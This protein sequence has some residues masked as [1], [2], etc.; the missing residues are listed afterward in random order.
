[1]A[2]PPLHRRRFL[3]TSAA[4]SSSLILSGPARAMSLMTSANDRINLG[5]IGIGMMGRSH[6]NAF[7]G[8]DDVQVVAVCDIEGTRRDNAHKQVE[9]RYAERTKS[10][11]Y[12]GCTAYVDF[13]ELLQRED[14]DAVV[15]ATPDHMHVIPC[16]MAATAGKDIYCEKPL[17]HSIHEGRM[18][19]DCVRKYETVFQ[20]GS[21]Q[22]SEFGG[23]FR[24]A[25]ELVRNG[26]LGE[27]KTVRVGVG[28]PPISCDL[29]AEDIPD[30]VNWD[31]WLGPAA[32]RPYSEILC[33]KGMHKHFPAFR[34]YQEFAGGGLADM[35]A[36][37]FDIAQWALGMDES[38]PV[39]IT[40]PAG[41]STSGLKFTYANGVEMFHG[42]PSGC[43]F[44][45]TEGTL[46][47]DRGQI[48]SDPGTILET[49]LGDADQRVYFSDNHKRN[50]IECI[51]TRK[52]PICDVEVGHRS[53]SICHLANISYRLGETLAWNPTTERFDSTEA[54]TLLFR[55]PRDGWTYDMG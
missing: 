29:P 35:G 23:K 54:N 40:P 36:H 52:R 1:M 44:E 53:A 41:G 16:M 9:S 39:K 46:Y 37:H 26:R 55:E 30:N 12:Q 13:R 33:P 47:V 6:L 32:F 21:Q 3:K 49:P 24:V 19:V 20:T 5:F 42:G 7:L 17:T 14:I 50:W 18:L 11:L 2:F 48:K 28:A 10:G 45:G 25:A 31:L 22:R 15:I 8:Q 4:L 43:T 34:K 38:G 27:I 51:R